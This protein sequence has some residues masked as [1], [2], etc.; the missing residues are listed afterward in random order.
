MRART[1]EKILIITQ[2]RVLKFKRINLERKKEKQSNKP[3]SIK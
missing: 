3:N 1:R 2:G